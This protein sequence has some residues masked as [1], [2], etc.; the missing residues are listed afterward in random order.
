MKTNFYVIPVFFSLLLLF[1]FQSNDQSRSL[2]HRS[3]LN[4]ELFQDDNIIAIADVCVIINAYIEAK[5]YSLLSEINIIERD[6]IK[7]SE[8]ERD[9]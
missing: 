7:V 8:S 6:S 5:T 9:R 4:R 2:I 3:Y 1:F